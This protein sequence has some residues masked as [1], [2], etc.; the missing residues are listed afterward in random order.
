MTS[1][2]IIAIGSD[3]KGYELKE[4]IHQYILEQDC[5]AHFSILDIG[6][7]DNQ[8]VD[9][10]DIANLLCDSIINNQA[11]YG[12]LICATGIGMSIAAN[13]HFDIRAALCFDDYMAEKSRLHNNANILVIGAKISNFNTIT[14]MIFK[15]ITTKFEGGRHL[16]RL[17]KLR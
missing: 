9:Y 7:H 14:N 6:T 2:N 10:P 1:S 4:K 5:F 12:I 8:Q 16:T 11:K 13:R 3:H 17:E 15:F